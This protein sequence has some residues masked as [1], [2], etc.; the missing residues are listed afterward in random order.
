MADM[1]SRLERRFEE[2]A[3]LGFGST[4]AG[5]N[6]VV[7]TCWVLPKKELL[8]LFLGMLRTSRDD[9]LPNGAR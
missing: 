7:K 5:R 4:Y 8:G 3:A 2:W 1:T 6:L 9:L